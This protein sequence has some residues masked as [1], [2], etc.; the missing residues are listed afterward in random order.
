MSWITTEEIDRDREIVVSKG[1]ND[2][3]FKLNPI[4]TYNHAYYLPPIGTSLWRKRATDGS[5]VGIKA[6]TVYPKKPD[7]WTDDW[8]PD[9]VLALI[10][11][12][13]MLGKSIG[14]I[15]LK[16]H[17]PSSHEIA[18]SPELAGVNRIIDEWLLIEYCCTYLPTNPNA[19]VEAVSKS[20]IKPEALQRLGLEVPPAP[21]PDP[22]RQGDTSAPISFTS[23]GEIEKSIRRRIDSINFAGIAEKAMQDALD[24]ARGRV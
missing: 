4:V 10:Q 22:Q 17:A 9:T 16:S 23:L 7:G 2:A 15:R 21:A 12:G 18:A 13:L 8:Q 1:M 14:F 6:K 3:A 20:R 11:S 19:L 24:R 5:L